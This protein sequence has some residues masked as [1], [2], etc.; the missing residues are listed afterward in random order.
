MDYPF[1]K[2]TSEAYSDHISSLVGRVESRRQITANTIRIL[3]LEEQ[4]SELRNTSVEEARDMKERRLEMDSSKV[5]LQPYCAKQGTVYRF[6]DLSCGFLKVSR[7]CSFFK[8]RNCVCTQSS[9]RVPNHLIH[10]GW[11]MWI[12]INLER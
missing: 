8:S 12:Q 1:V 5:W 6:S 3:L 4:N 10:V 7:E 11:A 2:Q 9:I